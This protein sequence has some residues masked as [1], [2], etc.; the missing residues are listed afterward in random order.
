[1][2]GCEMTCTSGSSTRNETKHTKQRPHEAASAGGR[3]RQRRPADRGG[4]TYLGR[5]ERHVAATVHVP[6]GEGHG[7]GA[8]GLGQTAAEVGDGQLRLLPAGRRVHQ[9]VIR[10]QIPETPAPCPVKHTDN[11]QA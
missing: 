8:A 4:G 10:L 2:E 9:Q 11:R 1:M 3:T 5:H 7:K 6:G